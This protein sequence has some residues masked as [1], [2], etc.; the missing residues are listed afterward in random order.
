MELSERYVYKIYEQ[1]SFSAAARALYIS[2]PALSST[3]SRLERDL[4]FRIFDRTLVP[5]A[6]TPEGAIYIEYLED[7]INSENNMRRRIEQLSDINHGTI[8][9][10][11]SCQSAY[12]V[13]PAI[14][15]EF[16]RR[17]PNVAVTVDAGST[18]YVGSLMDDVRKNRLDLVLGYSYE[19]REFEG[20][21]L[22][23]ERPVVAMHKDM[24]EANGLL[25]FSITR[26]QLLEGDYTPDME[27]QDLSV[28][29]NIQFLEALEWS[30]TYQKMETMLGRHRKI[31]PYNIKNVKNLSMHYNMMRAGVGATVAYD[32]HIMQS[33]FDDRDV[34]YFISGDRELCRTLYFIRKRSDGYSA[35]VQNFVELAK[36]VCA[37]MMPTHVTH[38]L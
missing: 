33:A 38:L 18:G 3:V 8:C 4:G 1:K 6:L 21:A 9:I 17:Y 5:L 36:T 16:H 23:Q 12:Y 22:M 24:A 10:G 19:P 32:T 14:C 28:F 37:D 29:R 11:G 20:I 34:V 27:L 26:C 25:S 30:N 7:K 13:L 31:S 15:G 35:V 2:Q